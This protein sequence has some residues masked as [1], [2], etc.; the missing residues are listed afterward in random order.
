MLFRCST[1]FSEGEIKLTEV[2][3]MLGASGS[4]RVAD[5]VDCLVASDLAGGLRLVN[6]VLDEGLDI[7]QFNRQTVEHLRQLML[8]K[9]G[10]SHSA[11]GS[12]LDVTEEMKRRMEAQAGHVGLPD[13]LRWT[14]VFAA[15]DSELRSTAY[16]QFGPRGGGIASAGGFRSRARARPR[17]RHRRAFPACTADTDTPACHEA[18]DCTNCSS[19]AGDR[20][21][22]ASYSHG[23]GRTR[24]ANKREQSG[25]ARGTTAEQCAPG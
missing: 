20:S 18:A 11:E 21:G 23:A 1:S 24:R 8:I 16:R 13:M 12:L 25:S 14:K 17:V 2:Q 22:S 5:F 3:D 9:T 19:P 6:T 7:R 4:E 15:A 10:A